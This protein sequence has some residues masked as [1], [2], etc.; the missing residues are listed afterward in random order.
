MSIEFIE[1]DAKR[2]YDE[3]IIA[4]QNALGEIL[5]PGDERRI[6]LEQ[7]AQLIVALYNAINESAKQNLLRYATGLVLDAIGES[8]GVIRLDAQ[9]A[10]CTVRFTLSSAQVENVV[11]PQG[12]RV[13]PDG[14]FFFTT[15]EEKTIPSGVLY[16]DISTEAT[17]AGADHNGFTSGQ[18]K[19]L[20]DII[21]FIG[22]VSNTDTSSAGAD[23]EADD[24]GE[25]VWSGYR[26]RIR[27]ANSRISTAGHELGYVYYAKSAD[28]NIEDVVVTS[29]EAGEVLITVLMKDAQMPSQSILDKVLA[30]CNAK[31]VRPMT[32]TVTAAAPTGISY[33]I[34]LTYYISE[35]NETGE[36]AIKTAV[37]ASIEAYKNWQDKK[38]GRAIN[39]DKLRQLILNAGACRVT[40]TAPTYTEITAIQIAQVGTTTVTYGGLE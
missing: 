14:V 39:P 15:I 25:N 9:K 40:L 29:P 33:N 21:P 13:T 16:A 1:V 23:I 11:I 32:D 17:V 22:S 3:M 19:T 2:I 20:V 4:F 10:V 36:T 27:L 26:E 37:M 31:N 28:A 5:Y 30:C 18:V 24:D 38:I 6:F 7:E 12:T 8:K 35:E 34:T